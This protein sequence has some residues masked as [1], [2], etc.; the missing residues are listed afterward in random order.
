MDSLCPNSRSE[1]IGDV[2]GAAMLLRSRG[3]VDE[4]EE[5]F[6]SR[7]VLYDPERDNFGGDEREVS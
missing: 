5:S 3:N 1:G 7:G 6:L 2:E 4:L